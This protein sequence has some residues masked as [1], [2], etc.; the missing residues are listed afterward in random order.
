MQLCIDWGNTRVKAALFQENKLVKDY[1]FSEEEALTGLIEAIDT[2]QPQAA[3]LASVANHPPELKVLLQER[4]RL[5]VLT[6]QTVLPIM[7]AYH[8]PETLGVDRLALATG[9]NSEY[10]DTN[11]LVIGIGTAITYNFVHKN[12]A[13]R[14]GNIT[15]GLAMRF[16]ALH[17]YT[18][19]L[20]L[21]DEHGD[22]VLLGYDTETSIRSGVIMGIAAELDGM[23][24]LYREQYPDLNVVLTGGNAPVF[25]GKLKNRIFADSLLL[26][27]GLNTIL[28]HNV[29]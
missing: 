28:R 18:D 6:A 13:F 21:V 10:P 17:E 16:K 12:R 3:I 5:L 20:P 23:I 15:P 2:E 24:N 7:N 25:A 1:N 9:A 22:L 8:S 19:K 26:L 27:K 4:T 29:R 11:N 14:G